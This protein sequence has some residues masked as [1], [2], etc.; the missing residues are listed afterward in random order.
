MP[1]NKESAL[2]CSRDGC[3]NV[4]DQWIAYAGQKF[5][6]PFCSDHIFRPH[7]LYNL[8][9]AKEHEL[10]PRKMTVI[11]SN[12]VKNI[13]RAQFEKELGELKAIIAAR[14]EFQSLVKKEH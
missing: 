5:P 6:L 7:L 1:S 14:E 3:A 13:D 11:P 9:K 2:I 4:G 8:Y 12:W 10:N